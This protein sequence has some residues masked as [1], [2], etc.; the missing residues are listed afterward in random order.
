MLVVR[1]SIVSRTIKHRELYA[2]CLQII[3]DSVYGVFVLDN[4][5]SPR[6]TS[7]AKLRAPWTVP[8]SQRRLRAD[9]EKSEFT[10]LSPPT[11]QP[12]ITGG[13]GVRRE[14]PVRQHAAG[15]AGDGECALVF[16]WV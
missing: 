14:C 13:W 2:E 15:D 16:V 6:L 4:A 3:Y 1:S 11:H 12:H 5:M 7:R 8:Y 9:P 10:M